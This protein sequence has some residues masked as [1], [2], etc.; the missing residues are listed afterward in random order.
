M[1]GSAWVWRRPTTTTT[2]TKTSTSPTS[3]RTCCT[4]TRVT[5]PLCDVTI[6]AGVAAGNSMGA[7]ACFLDI[8]AD[9][10]LDLL[11]VKYVNFTYQNHVAPIVHGLP[12][13]AGPKDYDPVADVLL[14]N[15]GDGSFTDISV[16][17]GI[18]RHRGTGMG[19][20]CL[21][22][23]QDGD[24][25]IVVVN[26]VRANFLYEN[27]GAGH[28]TEVGTLVGVAYNVDG[29]ELGSMGVDCGDLD[30]DGL[31]D[32]IQTSYSREMPALFHNTGIGFFEDVARA[33]GAGTAT[34]PHVNWGV[35]CAD[36]DND[37]W[38]DLYI[39]NGHLQDNV[40]LYDDL[41]RV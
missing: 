37:G 39:A 5:G 13:Y 24:T 25:D 8:E 38:R 34:F 6:P 16:E 4:R 3:A 9:G 7:A 30:N 41:D 17:S 11:A 23:D 15:N 28:F 10:D 33:W 19:A 14:R 1:W 32:L 40:Q 36:F 35:A 31:L 29:R 12:Q 20:V 26:D 21:D 18:A 27:D 22:Y 2:A